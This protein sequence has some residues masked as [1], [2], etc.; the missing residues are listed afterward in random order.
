MLAGIFLLVKLVAVWRL[1]FRLDILFRRPAG[2]FLVKLA[3]ELRT[4]F[5]ESARLRDM[6]QLLAHLVAH[7]MNPSDVINNYFFN[8]HVFLM[9][10]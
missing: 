8:F 4:F 3:S 1:F 9:F 6:R 7:R 5:A 10:N 2:I